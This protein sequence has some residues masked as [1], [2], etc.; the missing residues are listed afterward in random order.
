MATQKALRLKSKGQPLSLDEVPIPTSGPGSVVVKILGT[1]VL[2]YLPSVLDGS[3]PYPMTLP[4]T[5]GGSSIGRVYSVG[6]DSVSLEVGQLVYCDSTIHARDDPDLAILMGLHGGAA[7]KLMEGEWRHGTF[8]EYA[9]FPLENVFVLDE[10]LLCGELGYTIDDLCYLVPF[11]GLSDINLL[12]G[13]TVIVAPATGRFGGSAVTVALAMGASVVACGRNEQTLA[14]LRETF[15]ASGRL[16]TVVLT[17]D[18]DND[19]QAMVLA[20]GNGG[21]GA[22]AY[23]DFSPNAAAKSTH[24]ASAMAALRAFGKASFMGGIFG[25]IE[26]NYISL[27]MRSLR[28]QGRFM[29]TR[30]AVVRMIKMIEKGNLKLGISGGVKTIGKYGLDQIDE[31]MKIAKTETAWGKQVLLVP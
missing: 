2:S 5:P 20:A 8:A 19:T 31:A 30:E 7:M 24:I 12:P 6:A 18:Q 27:M 14:S 23:I 4:I 25:T 10:R 28:I 16:R 21:K 26:I 9:K 3:L 13:E 1:F 29:Y 17:G 15:D 22:D 11:G